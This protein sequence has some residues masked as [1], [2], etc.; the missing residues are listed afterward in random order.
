MNEIEQKARKLVEQDSFNDT[1]LNCVFYPGGE[2]WM[3][4]APWTDGQIENDDIDPCYEGVYRYLSG[5]PGLHLKKLVDKGVSYLWLREKGE[6]SAKNP[7]AKE[8]L[9]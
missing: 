6:L 5:Q 2:S 4:L 3:C 7:C 9:Q 1:C 8:A